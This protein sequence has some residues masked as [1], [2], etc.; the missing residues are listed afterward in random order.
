ME[1]EVKSIPNFVLQNLSILP[2]DRFPRIILHKMKAENHSSAKKIWGMVLAGLIAAT[3]IAWVCLVPDGFVDKLFAV[4]FAFCHQIESHS[5][6]M[7]QKVLPLCARCTGMYLG[8]L[9]GWMFL[10][11]QK[12]ASG[13]PQKGK[14]FLL[15]A[16][17]LFFVLDGTNSLAVTL[18]H[19][20]G[21]YPPQNPLRL[22]SGLGIGLV[23]ANVL[24][25]MW[26]EILWQQ[27]DPV[28]A[29]K[30]WL[31]VG[32]L[33]V[34]EGLMGI[35]ILT[36]WSWLYIPVAVLSILTIPFLLTPVYTLLWVMIFHKEN[37]FQNWRESVLF[38]EMG[39]LTT[40]V[41]IGLFDWLRWT[42]T[43]TW[44]GFRI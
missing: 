10:S 19:W 38:I 3:F 36:G 23:I 28:P 27:R 33:V 37:S 30:N 1:K 16:L 25:P 32:L 20:Q 35:L 29:L 11:R 26:N 24:Y 8:T 34:G 43:G 2:A 4:G 44:T 31:Q 41:Q 13:F 22:F 6:L 12:R 17:A 9:V 18:F 7:G 40:L 15:G 39:L 42:L 5:L 21:L 14:W